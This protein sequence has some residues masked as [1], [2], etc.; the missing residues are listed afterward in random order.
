MEIEVVHN[1]QCELGEG[2]VWDAD[3]E[4]I[5]W[6]D[7]LKGEIHQYSFKKGE[8]NLYSVD[9]MVGCI[10]LCNDNSL[11]LASK[12]GIGFFNKATS[13]I[14]YVCNPE[15]HL[16]KNRFND[17]KCDP[18]GRFWVGSMSLAEEPNAG[19][20]YAFENNLC[21]LKIEDTTIS[22]GMAWST[23]YQTYY[24][25][26]TPTSTVVSYDFDKN[27]GSIS[28]KRV[29]VTIDKKEG[30]P[31]GMTIDAEGMLWIAHWGGWQ[32]TRWNPLTGELL[33]RIKFPAAKITSCT[34][35]GKDL[36]DLFITSAKV[37]LTDEELKN[38]PL[39]GSLFVIRNCGYKGV[40][41]FKFKHR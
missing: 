13:E 14:E 8:Y 39:A 9:T 7:I 2:P 22:N 19:S 26:D 20:V 17:G 24:F 23:D 29:V 36:N 27:S 38:Q 41:P 25:I 5:Y 18:A 10:S 21:T 4:I 31:D 40:A 34:F 35:G 33:H 15:S 11:I 6:L 32:V 12:T 1:H 37:G 30:S 16:L 28:N 3:E